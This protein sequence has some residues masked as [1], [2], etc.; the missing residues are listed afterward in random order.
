MSGSWIKKLLSGPA[1]NRGAAGRRPQAGG[2]G[3]QG[4]VIAAALD[5]W[6]PERVKELTRGSQSPVMT[7]P[8]T[9]PDFPSFAASRKVR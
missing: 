3:E 9:M 7:C 8:L 1:W 4:R 5:L 6:L 2:R